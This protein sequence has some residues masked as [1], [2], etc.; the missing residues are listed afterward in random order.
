MTGCPLPLPLPLCLAGETVREKFRVAANRNE[1]ASESS[2]GGKKKKKDQSKFKNVFYLFFLIF[3][4]R[5]LSGFPNP[6][7]CPSQA[8]MHKNNRWRPSRWKDGLALQMGEE[9]SRPWKSRYTIWWNSL[10]SQLTN[11]LW[12]PLKTFTQV[13]QIYKEQLCCDCQKWKTKTKTKTSS[14]IIVIFTES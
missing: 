12:V 7:P 2:K 3:K 1:E 14:Q 5:E 10:A 13:L 11:E 6:S 4:K 8:T 9:G